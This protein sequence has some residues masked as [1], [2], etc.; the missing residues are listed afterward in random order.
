[1]TS[2]VLVALRIA[3]PPSRV[4]EAF[5]DEIGDWWRA[6]ALFR[7]GRDPGGRLSIEP[8]A[9]GRLLETYA[10]GEVDEIGRIVEWD[11][12]KRLVLSWRP[13]S[14]SSDQE[15]EVHVRFEPVDDLTR[16]T[17]EHVGWDAIPRE[18]ATRHG[19]PL[20]AFQ[21][22]LAE[23]WQDLLASLDEH[24]TG[25]RST[26]GAVRSGDEPKQSHA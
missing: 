23:W 2:R 10:N 19:F 7:S 14:F 11:P 13:T 3:A 26:G 1:M 17:V 18:H 5:T 12:P 8:R 20:L 21:Q 15:T 4:F 9:D 24:S 25:V 22:R 16:V 6:N